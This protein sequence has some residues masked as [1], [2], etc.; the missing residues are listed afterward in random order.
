M[1]K[2]FR[3]Y[4][5]SKDGCGHDDRENRDGGHG[6][7]SE[8]QAQHGHG[9]DARGDDHQLMIFP[10]ELRVRKKDIQNQR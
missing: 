7:P 6:V 10:Q 8:V 9:D 4:L 3:M 5:L 1:L 2:I